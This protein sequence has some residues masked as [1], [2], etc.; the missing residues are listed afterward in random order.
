L[1]V[2]GV[3]VSVV[4]V[5]GIAA[6]RARHLRPALLAVGVSAALLSGCAADH[7]Q[8]DGVRSAR[9]RIPRPAQALLVPPKQPFC[10]SSSSDSSS[11][12]KQPQG[13][14]GKVHGS[15]DGALSQR[16]RLEFERNCY[17]QAEM[18]ARAQLLRL[19]AAVGK[20]IRSLDRIDV[21]EAVGGQ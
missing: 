16:V 8:S 9:G 20:T 15:S 3:L 13:E 17:Q 12:T 4:A 1:V 5:G 10:T 7:P 6:R 14:P 11:E 19:Q 21:G 18:R 2:R